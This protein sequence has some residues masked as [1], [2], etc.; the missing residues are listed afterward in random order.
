[1]GRPLARAFI[2]APPRSA[3]PGASLLDREC[4]RSPDG[5]LA[6][7]RGAHLALADRAAHRLDVADEVE[8]LAGAHDPLEPHVVDAGKEGEPAAVLRL[9][10]H[11]HRT[12][13][14]ERLDHLHAR[15]DRVAG[16]MPGAVLVG[17]GLPGDH[18]LAWDELEYL[19]HEQEWIAMREDLLDLPLAEVGRHTLTLVAVPLSPDAVQPHLRGSFGRMYYY[20]VETPSTQ[21]LPPED[22]PH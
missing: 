6:A 4:Q 10:E 21:E 20:A 8:H 1:M 15:H 5:K 13:L 22:A 3:A 9:R 17:H 18:P 19:V 14:R 11:R 12:A 2:R 7:D 16:E